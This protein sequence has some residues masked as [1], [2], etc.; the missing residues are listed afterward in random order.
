MLTAGV[1]LTAAV[2]N[3]AFGRII[4]KPTTESVTSSTV[5][6]NDNDFAF[7]VVANAT[8]VLD[9]YLLYDGATDPA[10]GLKMQFTVPSGATF[11]AWTNFGTNGDITGSTLTEYNVVSEDAGTG[12]PRSIGTLTTAVARLT[13]QPRASLINGAN[14]GTLQFL[15]AQGASNATATRVLQGSWMRLTRVS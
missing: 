6:Q 10:G 1:Q 7:S 2:L 11:F 5:L 15:W 12:S 3:E 14:A 13:C 9:G 8:Y 4:V